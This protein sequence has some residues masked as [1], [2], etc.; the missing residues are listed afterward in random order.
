MFLILFLRKH[1]QGNKEQLGFYRGYRN[2]IFNQSER[3]YF[4]CAI[5]SYTFYITFTV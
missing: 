2:T 1:L 3:V 4:H 5:I